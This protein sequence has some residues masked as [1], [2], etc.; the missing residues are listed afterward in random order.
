MLLISVSSLT[1]L[2][3]L[4]LLGLSSALMPWIAAGILLYGWMAIAIAGT[5]GVPGIVL[6]Q[7]LAKDESSK[8]RKSAKQGAA[9]GFSILFAGVVVWAVAILQ[10]HTDSKSR[11]GPCI[12]WKD[13][14]VPQSASEERLSD[15][16]PQSGR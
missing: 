13:P 5:F 11:P 1:V 16:Q 7:L 9:I 8:Y 10:E 12:S 15:C 14:S 3:W 6:A 2:L 4:A